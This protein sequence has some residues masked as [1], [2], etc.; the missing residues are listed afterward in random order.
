MNRPRRSSSGEHHALKALDVEHLNLERDTARLLDAL[1]AVAAH[2]AEQR[3]NAAH[4]RPR[5]R[6]LEQG[7]GEAADG[8]TVRGG[9]ALEERDVA[10]GVGALVSGEVARVDRTA[11]GRLAR[12]RFHERAALVEAHER[13][14]GTRA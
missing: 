9:L 8:L 3:V 10:Q 11:A 4:A 12:V 7:V 14:I 2:E 13:S 6:D 1:G 5:Q